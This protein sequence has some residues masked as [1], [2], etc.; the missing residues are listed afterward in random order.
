MNEFRPHSP[1]FI[2]GVEERVFYFST[3]QELLDHP[4]VKMW[5]TDFLGGK[6]FYRYSISLSS[7]RYL[8]VE[9]NDIMPTT[10]FTP[11]GTILKPEEL[12]LPKFDF[13]NFDRLR[14][15][16]LTTINNS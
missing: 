6:A 4:S 9:F 12:D 16:P 13:N 14:L 1:H 2:D 15:E 7:D 3:L 11:I 10:R 8:I 5:R